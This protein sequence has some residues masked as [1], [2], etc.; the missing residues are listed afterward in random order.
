VSPT[1]RSPAPAVSP[2]GPAFVVAGAALFGTIGTARLL[3]PAAPAASVASVRLLLAAGLLVALAS[4]SGPVWIG[5]A[6]RQRPVWVAGIAQATFNLTFLAAVTRAGVAVGTLVAIGCTPIL[7]GLVAR[8]FTRGWLAATGL[9][10]V[11][12]VAL[13]SDGLRHGV[14]TSGLLLSLGASAS[15]ATFILA[16]ARPLPAEITLEARLAGVFVLAACCLV[17]GLFLTSLHWVTDPSGIAMLG[18]L[19][20]AATVIAYSLFNR[21]LRTV[22]AGTAA[23][24]GLTE[25]LI[26]AVLGVAVLGERLSPLSWAGAAIVFAAL[27]LMVRVAGPASS[28]PSAGGP[29]GSAGG[30]SRSREP[31]ATPRLAESRVPARGEWGP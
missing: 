24:L 22:P 12:L 13:L 1:P 20:V 21:G 26:A 17:P 3:G 4:R 27:A 31:V 7:T 29:A 25:P 6:L 9:A 18:Y 19:S 23:T 16:S 11:G 14:S 8:H 5:A 2:A 28:A 10:L 30:T 15:Y